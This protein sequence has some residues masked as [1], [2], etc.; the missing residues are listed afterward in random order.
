MIIF[1][2]KFFLLK[3][4]N[5]LQKKIQTRKG[6]I[7]IH[8]TYNNT[9]I[10]LRTIQG[11]VINWSSARVCGFRGA[12]KRTPFAAKMAIETVIRSGVKIGI[13]WVRIYISGPG[14]SRKISIRRIYEI[15]FYMILIRDVTSF[16]HNG[17]RPP[18]R[19]WIL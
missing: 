12:R 11:E 16:A 7:H 9:L 13:Q 6:I 5:N 14:P 8:S 3:Y 4:I 2:L 19:R 10:T 18:K 1:V 17:C 15:G